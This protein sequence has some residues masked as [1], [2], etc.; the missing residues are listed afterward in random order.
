M[1]RHFSQATIAQVLIAFTCVN[2]ALFAAYFVLS[3][4]PAP[5]MDALYFLDG[6][7][8]GIGSLW[9]QFGEQRPVI[10]R[11][12]AYGDLILAKGSG[13]LSAIIGVAALACLAALSV[14][15][16]LLAPVSAALRLA[17]ACLVIVLLTRTYA[18]ETYVWS[19]GLQF[20]LVASA[21]VGAL[22][23]LTLPDRPS[24]AWI[25][26][27]AALGLLASLTYLNGLVVWPLLVAIALIRR[28]RLTGV[29]A[30]LLIGLAL[31]VF[32]VADYRIPH[33]QTDPVGALSRPLEIIWYVL[34]FFGTPWTRS[35]S[36]GWIGLT[37]AAMLLALWVWSIASVLALWRGARPGQSALQQF[38]LLCCA[39][40]S[41]AIGTAFL[42]AAA[43]IDF[44]P[45]QA[46]Q[47]R[48]AP[49]AMIGHVAA[50]LF[51]ASR[52]PIRS[53]RPAQAVIAG[54]MLL[55]AVEQ[56][57]AGEIFRWQ[58][59][60]LEEVRIALLAG[61]REDFRLRQIY[62]SPEHARA[63]LAKAKARGVSV[64]DAPGASLVGTVLTQ[65]PS[66]QCPI[67]IEAAWRQ[68]GAEWGLVGSTPQRAD[69][70]AVEAILVVDRGNRVVGYGQ[71]DQMRRELPVKFGWHALAVP[72]GGNEG[73]KALGVLAEGALCSN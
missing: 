15:L 13:V 28:V 73:W 9:S 49:I 35:A 14:R 41:F 56:V 46:V 30:L 22:A 72:T 2:V 38:D 50:A 66:V 70:R 19:H 55:I 65:A 23:C 52:L 62:P 64:F 5:F 59:R 4:Y 40:L 60:T 45:L 47:S 17:L 39:T 69:G 61:S 21:A 10:M 43:R 29:A 57:L 6:A 48:Y 54:F 16:A 27:A 53:E 20:I 71:I 24:A 11:L 44:G 25:A 3:F 36:I 67:E 32:F 26:A 51:L 12:V 63:I 42:T 7:L 18:L 34:H 33:E 31:L 68:R 8:D 37:L 1:T 58:A